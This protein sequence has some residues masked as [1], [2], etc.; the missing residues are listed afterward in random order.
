MNRASSLASQAEADMLAR[1]LDASSGLVALD[2][3]D[4]RASLAQFRDVARRSGQALYLW[5]PQTGLSSLRDKHGRFPDCQRLGGALRFMRQS[6]HFGVY[7][8]LGVELPLSAADAAVLRQLAAVSSGHVRRVVLLN[9]P[10]TL[11]E[12]LGDV[13]VRLHHDKAA[14]RRLRL[15][16]G[17]WLVEG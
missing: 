7:F 10:A 8:V 9:P 16:D 2:C 15:R 5:E 13:V 1:I 11:V 4:A 6:M 12:H 14:A 3:V 17:R